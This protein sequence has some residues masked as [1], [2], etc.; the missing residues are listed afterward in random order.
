MASACIAFRPEFLE[1]G[2]YRHRVFIGR[3][4]GFE[5]HR[6]LL[7][8]LVELVCCVVVIMG[9]FLEEAIILLIDCGGETVIDGLDYPKAAY[10]YFSF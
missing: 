7:R 10:I 3:G 6:Y 2:D 9:R 5:L 8:H 1:E 4:E